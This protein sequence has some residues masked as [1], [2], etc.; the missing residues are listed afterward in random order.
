MKPLATPDC[1]EIWSTETPSHPF[2][3]NSRKAVARRLRCRRS[4]SS[5]VGRPPGPRFVRLATGLEIGETGVVADVLARPGETIPAG[6][7]V[8]P[9]FNISDWGGDRLREDAR[10]TYGAPP[11]GNANYAWLQHI[12]WHLA[13]SPRLPVSITLGAGAGVTQ[14]HPASAGQPS[15]TRSE[16]TTTFSVGATS[17]MRLCPAARALAYF[18]TISR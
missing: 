18:A 17:R 4:A 16:D 14:T 6:G 15:W 7:P 12:L 3:R 13:P 1:R 8:H 10:W 2:S 9:P 5:R 11:V